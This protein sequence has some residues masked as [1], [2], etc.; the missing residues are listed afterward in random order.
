MAL[1]SYINNNYLLL[2]FV[3]N[4]PVLTDDLGKHFTS[5]QYCNHAKALI[6]FI[7]IIYVYHLSMLL[8]GLFTLSA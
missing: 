8:Q 4:S 3:N 7:T 2:K 6:I 1:D 5:S